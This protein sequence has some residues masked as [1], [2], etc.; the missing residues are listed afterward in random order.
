[1]VWK[2]DRVIQGTGLEIRTAWFLPVASGPVL[3]AFS[4]SSGADVFGDSSLSA[5]VWVQRWERDAKR[6]QVLPEC[7][8]VLDLDQGG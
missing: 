4:P 1:M 3:L 8:P 7:S 5:P 2:A 6:R